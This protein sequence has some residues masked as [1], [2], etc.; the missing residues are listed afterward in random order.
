M[1]VWW[2]DLRGLEGWTWT[3]TSS[4]GLRQELGRGTKTAQRQQESR[5][6]RFLRGRPGLVQAAVALED[7]WTTEGG[8]AGLGTEP[9]LLLAHCLK[10]EGQEQLSTL[11]IHKRV[12]EREIGLPLRSICKSK[13]W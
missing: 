12:R 8:A 10:P 7:H 9:G 3:L 4:H 2:T 13:G 1:S 6:P 11:E 5:R